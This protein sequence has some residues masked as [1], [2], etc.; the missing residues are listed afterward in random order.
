[1]TT[2]EEDQATMSGNVQGSNGSQPR[3]F[4]DPGAR[5]S[6]RIPEDWLVDTFGQQGSSVILYHPR[7]GSDFRTNVNVLVQP[8]APLSTEEYLTLSRLQIRK[9]TGFAELPADAPAGGRA[10]AH[11]F[12]WMTNQ[13]PTP[14]RVRQLVVFSEESAFVISATASLEEFEA[15]RGAFDGIFDSFELGK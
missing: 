11:V 2:P 7:V 14:V 3:V 5:F 6:L 1:M 15:H 9:L 10:D 8:L 13:A 12:E 4:T